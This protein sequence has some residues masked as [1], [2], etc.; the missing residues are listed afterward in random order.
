MTTSERR[1]CRERIIPPSNGDYTILLLALNLCSSHDHRVS[2]LSKN[3][4]EM[5]IDSEVVVEQKAGIASERK[6]RL[7][8]E[9]LAREFTCADS[10][11]HH[12][13]EMLTH[14]GQQFRCLNCPRTTCSQFVFGRMGRVDG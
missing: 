7:I 1:L 9:A 11:I 4:V 2:Y 8:E 13:F 12:M 6:G 14:I 3:H 5:S 10:V